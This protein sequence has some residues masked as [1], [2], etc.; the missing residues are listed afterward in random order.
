MKKV[1]VV[2]D[3]TVKV[4]NNIKTVIG[5]TSY[6]NI[7]LKR[8]TVFERFSEIINNMKDIEIIKISNIIKY[9][10]EIKNIN[11]NVSI[12]HI[13]SN[14]AIKNYEEFKVLIEKIPY[15]NENYKIISDNKLIGLAFNEIEQ[16]KS[17]L[18]AF[19]DVEDVQE[20]VMQYSEIKTEAFMDI[21]NYNNLLTYISGGFDARFFNSL[22]GNEYIV[23][24][25]STNKKKIKQEYCYYGLLPDDMKKWMVMP[26]DYKEDEKTSQYTMERLHMTDIAIRWTH[27]AIDEEEFINILNKSFYYIVNRTKKSISKEK[28]EELENELYINK[29]KKR[30]EELKKDKLFKKFD[31]FIKSGTEFNSIDEIFEF[32]MQKYK[33][34]SKV[35]KEN[36][37]VIGHGDLCFANMLY[38]KETDM[39][40]LI[41]PKGALTE[42]ELWTN[43]YYDIAKLSHSICGNYDFFNCSSYSIGLNTNLQYELKVYNDN[44]RAKE[45]FKNI[46]EENGYS[47]ELVRLYEASLFLSMLPLHMDYPHK[48][49]G[50]LL[51]AINI[52]KEI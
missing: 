49:F 45:I 44:N 43:P 8:K 25:K 39:L 19:K 20:Q 7:I 36:I 3:D 37:A 22:E 9:Y 42:D 2:Y 6:G 17:F 50:F 13:F 18:K 16:Y 21:S 5:K 31:M 4:P 11:Q 23:T 33:K 47:Y 32:Y 51:N 14:Y 27:K 12:I 24:K 30:I 29:V 41:D 26:Y 10:N 1:I 40:K 34:L 28:Y 46:V 48:V 15:I 52:L 38:S 35:K